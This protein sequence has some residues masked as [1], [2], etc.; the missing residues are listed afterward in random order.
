MILV[1]C[2]QRSEGDFSDPRRYLYY[3]SGSLA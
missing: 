3:W 1:R 2:V